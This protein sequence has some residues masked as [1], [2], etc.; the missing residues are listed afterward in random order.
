MELYHLSNLLEMLNDRIMVDTE[1][2]NTS[3]CRCKKISFDDALNWILSASN[4]RTL[5][6]SSSRLLPPL[7]N[8][9]NHHCTV[10]SLAVPRPNALLMFQVVFAAL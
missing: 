10:Y 8:F 1:F 6:S 2:F 7:Q 9:L 3:L 4:G 5:C